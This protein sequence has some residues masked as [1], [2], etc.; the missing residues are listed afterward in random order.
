MTPNIN[1]NIQTS[2]NEKF[3][4]QN[5]I[6][7]TGASHTFVSKDFVDKYKFKISSTSTHTVTIADT[8]EA[9]V[10]GSTTLRFIIQNK[11]FAWKCLVLSSLPFTIVLGS[12]FIKH[13]R[14]VIDLHNQCYY[15]GNNKE[16]IF[17]FDANPTLCLLQGLN[18][19][20]RI[21]LHAM[22]NE[23]TDVLVDRVG[24][25]NAVQCKLEVSSKPIAQKAYKESPAKHKIIK[26]HVKEMLDLGVI[27]PSESEW[28][29]PVALQKE[30]GEY[31]F[32]L[33]YRTLNRNTKSDPFP[34]PRFEAVIQRLSAAQFI[35]KI[36]LKKGYWQIEMHP[37]SIPYTAFICEDGKFEFT[38]MPFGLKTAPSVFQRFVNTLLGRAKGN[39]A[40]GYLDD[41][42]VYSSTWEEHLDHLRFVL[43]QLQHA[44]LT[45]N[46]KKCSF[47]Q[48]VVEYLGYLIT[49]D[50]VRINPEKISP[51][52]DY[53]VPRTTKDVKR[54]LGLC[55]WYRQYVPHFATLIEP[56]NDCLRKGKKFIWDYE[57]QQAFNTI[58]Q[59]IADATALSLPDFEKK[60]ILRT[61]SSDVGLGAVLAQ[62]DKNDV[63]QP[64]AFASRTLSKA[65]RSYHATEK[66]CLGIVWALKKFTPYLDGQ[67]FELQT[68]NRALTWLDRMKDVN[69]KF[70][71]WALCIQDFQPTIIHI[72]G[73]LNT[74]ADAL[75]RAPVGPAEEEEEKEVMYPPKL[76]FMSH[77][78]STI[79]R[80]AVKRE[81]SSDEETMAL[82]RNLPTGFIIEDGILF[83]L[84]RKAQKL[85]FIPKVLRGEILHYFHDAPQ[86]GHLGFRKTIMRIMRRFFWYGIHEDVFDYIKGCE[87]CQRTKNP[88]TKPHG[89]LNPVKTNGPWDVLAMD[90]MGPLPTTS[91][92]NT[93]LLVVVDHFS[94]WIEI[95]PMR[96]ATAS[97]IAEIVE[98]EIFCRYG[99]PKS[100]LSDNGSNFKSRIMQ[101]LCNSWGINHKF[102][103]PYHPQANITER[104]N[105]NIRAI[106]ATYIGQKH[107]KWDEFLPA[108]AL[109]LRTAVSDTTGYSPSLLTFGR[110]I[111]LPLD[112]ALEESGE[113]FESRKAHCTELITKLSSIY[114]LARTH[115]EK[116]QDVQAKHYNKRHK[117]MHYQV[118]DLVM[119]RTHML[120][121]KA[122]R[123]CK[124]FAF[125]WIGPYEIS[126]VTSSGAYH[127]VDP[128]TKDQRGYHNVKDL[129]PYFDRPSS[130]LVITPMTQ[131]LAS[132]N[133]QQHYNLRI[134]K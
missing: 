9:A 74:V 83:K 114:A 12:D 6:L 110:E 68:D 93:Q 91:K 117:A 122:K 104:I 8:S 60:F 52:M 51:I 70:M 27:R 111:R 103:S 36:D 31:R 63:E 50:G 71:R 87:E 53:P 109:A 7:D 72:P 48:P 20:R 77:L 1:I 49:S 33:D 58:K 30:N 96:K 26:K 98:K 107:N 4:T 42:L 65:E 54:F 127:I 41:I 92:Q 121:N 34:I 39:F 3:T 124:K 55:G 108:V 94:K 81:Q 16:V 131:T 40:D 128:L 119:L 79:D 14:M 129:K 116:A 97:K 95:F 29:S 2:I 78:T 100:I 56:L 132:G 37:E 17:P 85:F 24:K 113:E 88:T 84:G 28:A 120:S 86:A 5:C 64:I 59:L 106:L 35:S 25:T 13:A 21:Q 90:L 123:F 73:R 62:I 44:N 15:F 18:R 47:A 45:A 38:R 19:D 66:E 22:L 133:S 10:M 134:R 126:Q 118:G 112:R 76:M 46:I 75:S 89:E 11:E 130:P 125:R 99:A 67:E 101:N 115:I 23:F 32:C 61:D 57:Q 69:S 82:L 105:R 80:E 102:I 43:T